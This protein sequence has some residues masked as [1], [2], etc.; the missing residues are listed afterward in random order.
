MIFLFYYDAIVREIQHEINYLIN[1]NNLNKGTYLYIYVYLFIKYKFNKNINCT[2]LKGILTF[3][4]F[5]SKRNI[6]INI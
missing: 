6:Y 1:T 3:I 5:V 2:F 4:I